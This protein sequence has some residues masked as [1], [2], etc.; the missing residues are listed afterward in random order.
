[1]LDPSGGNWAISRIQGWTPD[2]VPLPHGHGSVN[3]DLCTGP[4]LFE[5]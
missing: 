5:F 2:W 1:M 4:S 3:S